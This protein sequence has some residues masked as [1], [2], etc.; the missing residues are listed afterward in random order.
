[1][2]DNV[3]AHW[4]AR[5][6]FDSY[7]DSNTC[8]SLGTNLPVDAIL[9]DYGT[10]L[11][12]EYAFRVLPAKGHTY[13]M[14]CLIAVVDGEKI[15]FTGDLLTT[16]GKLYQ[17]HAM[18]Y[19]YGDLLGIE[20]TMQSILAL[21]KES[22]ETV[23]PSHG[24]PIVEVKADIVKLE[25]RLERLANTGRLLTS[26]R[27]N[28]KDWETIRESRL[29]PITEHLLWAGPYTCSNFYIVLSGSGHAMLIDYGLA[30]Y[31]HLHFGN[32]HDGMQALRFIEHHIDQLRDDYGA[33]DIELV[34]PTHIHDDHICGIPFLQRHFGTQCWALDCVAEIIANPAAWASTPCC[35]N[36]PIEVQRI[37]RDGEAFRWRGF[38]F[39]VHYA[40]GQTEYHSIVSGHIDG[41]RIVF[42]G[43]NVVLFN[44]EAGGIDRQ[45]QAGG[46]DR[47]ILAQTTVMRNS[48]Q[49]D[50]HRR[51][52]NVMRAT[53]PDLVCL[54]HGELITMDQSRIAEYAEYI[55][56]KELAFRDIVG[57]P[58]NH[59]ID[60]FW[61]RMLP[62]LSEASPNSQVTYTVRIRNNLERTALYS[63]RLLPAFGW[64]SRAEAESIT[65]QPGEQD[66]IVLAAI[67]PSRVDPRRRL[68]TAEI[69]ID[70]VSQGPVCEALVSTLSA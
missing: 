27:T 53:R 64:T 28:F 37:L 50:M 26:G 46:I 9:E 59:F 68:I 66:E 16:G 62:Y 32:D 42:G 15:A 67:A 54:G 48:F 39:E 33:R 13:G 6:I 34:V 29:Q 43:D 8:F 65:L 19:S 60:L 10:F 41:K 70:G 38:D 44:P 1:M 5:G 57:E 45:I 22:V 58:A 17:L 35:F 25:S 21:K 18:E 4:Q 2:F 20:F 12:K 11:W 55:E 24:L 36:K 52:A 61:A 63:A 47:Q 14:F 3:E 40:P 7:N 56:R 49:L 69:L 30:S 31:G 51:C 23:Y